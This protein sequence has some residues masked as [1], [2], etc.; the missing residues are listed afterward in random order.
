M[1]C[2]DCYVDLEQPLR[3]N[4]TNSASAPVVLVIDDDPLI[5][6]VVRRAMEGATYRMHV[7]A[8]GAAGVDEVSRCQPDVVILDNVLPDCLGLNALSGIDDEDRAFGGGE[9][10]RHFVDE[11]DVAGRVNQVQLIRLAILSLVTHG[12]RVGL[13][14]DPPFPL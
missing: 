5:P 9:R 2:A 8:D 14:R 4:S 12:H 1:V 11:I 6:I 13:D 3:V 7:A 10:S